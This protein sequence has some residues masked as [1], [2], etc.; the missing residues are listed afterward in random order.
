MRGRKP[1]GYRL[2]EADRQSLHE[3]RADGQLMHRVAN[4]ARALLALDRGE[5]L[6]EIARWLGWSRMGLWQLWQ[7][8]HA[9]GVAAIFDAERCGR[10]SGFSPP[11]ACPH[12]TRRVPGSRS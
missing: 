4:R 3:I 9:W 6:A 12:R 11:G 10:P 5:R 8:D 2:R 7:R 1:L